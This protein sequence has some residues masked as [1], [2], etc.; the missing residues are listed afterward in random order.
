M[1]DWDI[2]PSDPLP[3]HEPPPRQ[4]PAEATLRRSRA[5]VKILRV[6]AIATVVAG[7]IAQFGITYLDDERFGTDT[8]GS[9]RFYNFLQGVWFPF[10]WSGLVLAASAV[11]DIMTTRFAAEHGN[12]G[13]NPRRVD[14]AGDLVVNAPGRPLLSREPVAAGPPP[15]DDA[16]WQPPVPTE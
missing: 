5:A 9:T 4:P 10:V 8:S 6:I 3:E 11:V 14:A 13:E 12:G 7:V 2:R 15:I 16:I 1:A